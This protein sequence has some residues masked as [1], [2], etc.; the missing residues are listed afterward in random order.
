MKLFRFFK[1]DNILL[2]LALTHLLGFLLLGLFPQFFTGEDGIVP[3]T[4]QAIAIEAAFKVPTWQF[5]THF[6]GTDHLGRDVLAGIIY[7]CK[8]SL[9]VCFPAMVIAAIIGLLLGLSAG[10]FGNDSKKIPLYSLP[11]YMLA[12]GFGLYYGFYVG[13]FSLA[14]AF[15]SSTIK[16]SGV[17]A[18]RISIIGCVLWLIYFLGRKA[19][20]TGS[21]FFLPVDEIVLKLTELFSSVPRLVLILSVAAFLQPSLGAVILILGLTSWTGMAR[22]ARGEVIRVRTLPYIEAA[23]ALGLEDRSIVSNHVLPNILPAIIVA[24]AFGLANL[25]A[26][27]TTLSFLGIGLPPDEVSWGKIISGVRHNFSAWWLVVFPGGYLSLTVL[28]LH[29][30][31]NYFMDRNSR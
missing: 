19:K 23:K 1:R 28:A 25:L 2:V 22:L 27:E 29:Y 9:I 26:L 12:L 5:D 14:D 30:C 21:F 17:L 3:F 8:T 7:G 18:L 20:N 16:G 24:F 10:Y 31:S 11:L 6:F 15:T 13:R 4:A